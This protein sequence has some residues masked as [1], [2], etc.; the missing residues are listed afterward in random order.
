M[1]VTFESMSTIF[2]HFLSK[3]FNFHMLSPP[4]IQSPNPQTHSPKM[5][6]QMELSS[7]RHRTLNVNGINLHIAEK[8]ESGPLILFIHGFP[9]LWYSWRYQILD[10]SSRGYRAVAPDLRGY[11][12]SDSP[13][14]V[15]D[16]TCFHIVG[17]LIALIDAIVGVEEKVFVVGHDWGAMIAWNLCMYRPDRVK[18]LVNTSVTFNRRSPKRK[19]IPALKALYGDDYYICRFQEPGE[20]EAEFAEIGTERIMTEILSYRIPKPLMMPKG[21]GKGKDHPLDT[22]ISLP[23]WLTKQDMDYYV[24]K[25]DKNGFT[26]PINYYRN[27]DRNWE[28]N[29]P[30]TGAQVKVPTKFI[31]G[32]QDLTYNSFGAKQYIES[33]EMK[34][35]VPFLEEV[36]VME[37]VGH[38]L[39]EEKPHEISNHIYEFIKNY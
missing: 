28:L 19:P 16:Y 22:P 15:N 29:A 14:S 2:R 21:R 5:E 25:F 3:L 12:D 35:D 10:L 9:E 24:S 36:V 31:V 30:F 23:P 6:N 20:I 17:D 38:F 4:I 1:K 11:G 8:G 39:Q 13:P 27:L 37:G 7:I 33:G 26:G 32:D 18:A 34:K